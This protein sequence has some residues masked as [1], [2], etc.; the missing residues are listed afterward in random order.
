VGA[1]D[2]LRRAAAHRPWPL[3]TGPWAMTMSWCDL[4]FAHWPLPAEALRPLLP[5]GLELDLYEGCAWL[6]VVPF[7]MAHVGPRGLPDLP[8]ISAFPELNV[9]TYAV[10]GGKPGVWFFSLDAANPAA[11]ALARVG[12][13]LPYFRARMSLRSEGDAIV[14]SSERTHRGAP[15]A[16]FEARYAPRNGSNGELYQAAPGTLDHWLTE[17]Y[18]LYAATPTRLYRGEIHHPPW[19]LQR[20]ELAV[21]QNTVAAA[22][23]LVL[24]AEAPLLHFAR[25]Q[26]VLAWRPTPVAASA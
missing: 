25:Q 22:S 4:L 3:P 7:R 15:P 20:A 1:W 18:C 19:A 13:H 2:D 14:Y 6:S 9:R 23:G 26:D 8:W 10:A 12:F 11:V 17:R 16:R 5:R 21:E 24:P